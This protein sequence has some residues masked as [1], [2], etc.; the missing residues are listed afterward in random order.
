M[1]SLDK[2]RLIARL[3]I[4]FHLTAD[5]KRAFSNAFIIHLRFIFII[6]YILR[7]CRYV[8][9]QRL[10]KDNRV[11]YIWFTF[12]I[13]VFVMQIMQLSR[14][15]FIGARIQFHQIKTWE[16][17]WIIVIAKGL[18]ERMHGGRDRLTAVLRNRWACLRRQSFTPFPKKLKAL[19]N[20]L[21]KSQRLKLHFGEALRRKSIEKEPPTITSRSSEARSSCI[22]P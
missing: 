7:K 14:I 19:L 6:A 15:K 8:C 13:K 11:R 17:N 21:R 9:T 18:T 1:T 16:I 10:N 2:S 5:Y 12:S 20:S 3:W 4:K 22:S